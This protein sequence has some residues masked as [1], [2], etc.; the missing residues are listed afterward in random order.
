MEFAPTVVKTLAGGS[1]AQRGV[2]AEMSRVGASNWGSAIGEEGTGPSALIFNMSLV[3]FDEGRGL[4]LRMSAAV[5]S[6][7][8]AMARADRLIAFMLSSITLG[9]SGTLWKAP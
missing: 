4:A 6:L 7:L 2:I 3:I 5:R 8:L 1:G 9:S